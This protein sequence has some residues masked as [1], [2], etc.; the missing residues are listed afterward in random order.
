MDDCETESAPTRGGPFRRIGLGLKLLLL[1]IAMLVVAYVLIYAPE[2]H[3]LARRVRQ[4]GATWFGWTW[5][6]WF[7]AAL[8]WVTAA[9]AA[10]QLL[11][12]AGLY[13]YALMASVRRLYWC[14]HRRRAVRRWRPIA[15]AAGLGP[16]RRWMAL[17]IGT[18]E[19]TKKSIR[20]L[21]AARTPAWLGRGL[22]VVGFAATFAVWLNMGADLTSLPSGMVVLVLVAFVYLSDERAPSVFVSQ[23]AG[24]HAK[25]D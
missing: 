18:N 19:P 4:P 23:T 2:I 5:P 3:H 6:G 10:A 22:F 17:R 24:R 1:L 12:L 20:R 14:A 7:T 9:L 11:F 13:G 15:A 25:A 8:W 21:W 16:V